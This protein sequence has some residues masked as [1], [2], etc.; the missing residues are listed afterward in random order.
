[1]FERQH[2]CRRHVARGRRTLRHREVGLDCLSPL[3]EQLRRVDSECQRRVNHVHSFIRRVD[4]G[5]G[6]C[7]RVIGCVF[8]AHPGGLLK[9]GDVSL[10]RFA[11]RRGQPEPGPRSAADRPFPDFDVASVFQEARLLRQHRVTD[12]RGVAQRGELD[13]VRAAGE[14]AAD[15]RPGNRVNDRIQR[16]GQL[17]LGSQIA[18][19]PV[20]RSQRMPRRWPCEQPVPARVASRLTTIAAASSP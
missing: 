8:G 6:W 3:D 13:P 10:E 11:S 4:G 17:A 12:P 19:L 9:P 20:S 7:C 18:A 14:Q 2:R 16:G 1:M 15:R 5:R